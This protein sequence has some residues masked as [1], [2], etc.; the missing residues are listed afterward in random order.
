[1]T[2]FI[3]LFVDPI[4]DHSI[5]KYSNMKVH[6]IDSFKDIS[7]EEYNNSNRNDNVF[8]IEPITYHDKDTD[9]DICLDNILPNIIPKYCNNT[10]KLCE[11]LDNPKFVKT[12]CRFCNLIY[13]IYITEVNNATFVELL[14]DNHVRCYIKIHNDD[15]TVLY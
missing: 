11:L 13:T 15:I 7:E 1:M 9:T 10:K 6:A 4:E 3:K 5:S 14:Y 8:K 2:R 12:I